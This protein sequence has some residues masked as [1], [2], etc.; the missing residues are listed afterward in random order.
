MVELPQLLLPANWQ[1]DALEKE[2]RRVYFE[3]LVPNAPILP[4]IKGMENL[5]LQITNSEGAFQH[6]FG[7]S[8]GWTSYRHSKTGA[9]DVERLRRVRWIRP[10]LE[11][12]AKGTKIYVN[13]HS[14]KPREHG[15]KLSD[16]RKRLYIVTQT[17]LLYFIGLKYLPK[18]FVLTTAFEPEG[19]WIR[20][21]IKKHR[22]TL[23]WPSP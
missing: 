1:A 22:T 6:I 23:L 9:L 10:V 13:A 3:E 4:E 2:A 11:L 14:M 18:S 5:P 8:E 17:G 7:E 16:D 15:Q 12:Q 21:T 20:E 19:R